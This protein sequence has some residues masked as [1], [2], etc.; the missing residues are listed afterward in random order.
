MDLQE[1]LN[2]LLEKFEKQI[3]NEH[4]FE[5]LD[6]LCFLPEISSSFKIAKEE[7]LKPNSKYSIYDK[8]ELLEKSVQNTSKGK[9]LFQVCFGFQK[10][11]KIIKETHY[12]KR[13]FSEIDHDSLPI[14]N[15]NKK[16]KVQD[17]QQVLEEQK[18]MGKEI[19]N[20]LRNHP[21]DRMVWEC[22]YSP[23]TITPFM[24]VESENVTI[25][26]SPFQQPFLL[27]HLSTPSEHFRPMNLKKAYTVCVR[28][29]R[30]RSHI[31]GQPLQ[32]LFEELAFVGNKYKELMNKEEL[33]ANENEEFLKCES[34]IQIIKHIAFFRRTLDANLSQEDYD[35]FVNLDESTSEFYNKN[36]FFNEL[37]IHEFP[38][39]LDIQSYVHSG[40]RDHF[41][42]F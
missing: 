13:S 19:H 3:Q 6:R 40:F 12:R 17:S 2:T 37:R 33:D 41:G 14:R 8:I 24:V 5:I 29:K 9:K 20:Y 35:K 18:S 28:K 16:Q 34:I 36:Y 21:Y 39:I 23:T 31:Q 38:K 30:N 15:E 42:G 4:N 22:L 25:P 32:K 26:Q 27:S 1:K 11:L 7:Y 10:V